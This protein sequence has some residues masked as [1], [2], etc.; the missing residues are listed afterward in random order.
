M[1]APQDIKQFFIEQESTI[2]QWRHHLHEYPEIGLDL[3]ETTQ[4]VKDILQRCAVDELHEGIGGGLVAV[5]HGRGGQ[6]KH[7]VGLRTDMDAL[8][9]KDEG[10]HDHVSLRE[11]RSHGCGHDGHMT[12]ALAT[13]MYLTQHRDFTGTIALIFQPGEEGYA[14]AR[15]MIEDGLFDRFP[16][17]EVYAF[18]GEPATPA[19]TVGI[20]PG[21]IMA[22][23]D[24][25]KIEVE[26]KGGHGAHPDLAI[27]SVLV[28]SQIVVS[29]QSIVSRNVDPLKG[30]VV[31][32]GACV[33]GD[34][35]GSSVLPQK[36]TLVGTCRTFE[37]QVQDLVERR[38]GEIAAGTAQAYG[39]KA[40]CHYTRLYPALF[41]HPDQ[42]QAVKDIAL[43][44]VGADAVLDEPAQMIAEDFAF[45]MQKRPGCLFRLG[46]GDAEHQAGLHNPSFDFN[47]KAIATGATMMTVIGL[48]R[49][50]ALSH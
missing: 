34:L 36:A 41:N 47:D 16:I 1:Q 11:K 18:H 29:S 13:A 45:M 35:N 49:A 22:A 26:G 46:L 50:E 37:P 19:G 43:E 20:N 23:A 14:G 39:A 15:H 3:P 42:A 44:V 38:L 30:A 6:S 5:I 27:D 10:R 12:V 28:A 33:A 48:R 31:T 7:W 17:D 9:L 40:Q 21:Y 24:I 8:P 32:F 4:F 2:A 25:F